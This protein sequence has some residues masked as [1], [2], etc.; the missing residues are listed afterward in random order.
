VKKVAVLLTL[1]FGGHFSYSS[2]YCEALLTFAPIVKDTELIELMAPETR[3]EAQIL[4]RLLENPTANLEIFKSEF[5]ATFET[6]RKGLTYLERNSTLYQSDKDKIQKLRK[7]LKEFE[8]KPSIRFTQL[9][10]L[11]DFYLDIARK[12]EDGRT[13]FKFDEKWK[14]AT[15]VPDEELRSEVIIR[16]RGPRFPLRLPLGRDHDFEAMNDLIS[17]GILPVDLKSRPTP[18]DGDI[19]SIAGFTDHDDKDHNDSIESSFQ[20]YVREKYNG[21]RKRHLQEIVIL[22][23]EFKKYIRKHLT[24]VAEIIA[25]ENI[26]FVDL[27]EKV[28][29]QSSTTVG[30]LEH[31]MIMLDS[32]ASVAQSR[33]MSTND[34][35]LAYPPATDFTKV[36]PNAKKVVRNFLYEFQ[37][38][39]LDF[40]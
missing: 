17:I 28:G 33:A 10:V 20:I 37:H 7:Y 29:Y 15:E 6:I 27:H 11:S 32:H 34:Y 39:H 23:R 36:F 19:K 16:V 3:A 25:A 21:D 40:K 14:I 22:R 2:T 24:D 35:G 31:F 9:S 13:Y 1:F 18:A 26:F 5:K 38:R 4:F 8:S 12:L 30:P